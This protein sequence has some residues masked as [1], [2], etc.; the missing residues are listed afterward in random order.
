MERKC[1]VF[2]RS[3]DDGSSSM[4]RMLA[5]SVGTRFILAGRRRQNN[6]EGRANPGRGLIFQPPAVALHDARRNGQTQPRAGF[7]GGEEGIEEPLLYF[8]RDAFAI[9][10][11]F[12]DD[13]VRRLVVQVFA[14]RAPGV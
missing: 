2:A 9:V 8:G 1:A 6:P 12:Q 11:D 5:D 4:S 10:L 14:I 13:D 3:K 7:L